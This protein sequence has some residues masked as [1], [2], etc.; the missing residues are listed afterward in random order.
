MAMA[1]GKVR[2]LN[3]ALD[4]LFANYEK[5]LKVAMQCAAKKAKDDI[6]QKAKSCLWQYYENYDPSAYE[7]YG[8][9]ENAFIPYMRVIR[10]NEGNIMAEAGMGY[11]PFMLDGV[12]NDG[13]NQWRPVESWWVLDNYLRGIHPTTDGSTYVGAPYTPVFDIE[14]P[15]DKMEKYLEDYVD[16][17]N[18]NILISFAEQIT[19]R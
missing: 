8:Y 17:F 7:R 19:R 9:L 16:T 3:E 1:K 6:E 10:T 13:S 15:D 5:S 2:G 11:W 18:D 12:C 4:E 14:S